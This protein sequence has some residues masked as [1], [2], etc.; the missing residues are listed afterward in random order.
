MVTSQE[1]STKAVRR[2]IWSYR[3]RITLLDVVPAVWRTLLVPETITLPKL[4]TA[5]QF[6]MGWTNSHLWVFRSIVTSHFDI[7]TARF[8]PT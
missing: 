5:F 8:G 7:V 2:L 4:H 6:T 3:L 1:R